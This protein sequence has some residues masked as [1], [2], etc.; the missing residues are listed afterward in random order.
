MESARPQSLAS[1]LVILPC[2][3]VTA[4]LTLGGMDWLTMAYPDFDIMGWYAV[5]VIPV[6][7]IGVGALA[8]S[9]YGAMSWISGRK[10]GG[11]LLVTILLLQ[12]AA[13]AT[14]Q[15]LQFARLGFTLEDGTP[16]PFLA[17]FDAV[18]RS[19]T[20]TIGHAKVTC[21]RLSSAS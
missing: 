19:M 18:R 2:G 9:G 20:L 12:A 3:I 16:V 1:D 8:G 5:L 14:A 11:G 21:P 7:A 15:W 13:Y 10:V 17:A 6:G 4:G